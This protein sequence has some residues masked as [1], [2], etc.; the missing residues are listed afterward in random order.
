MRHVRIVVGLLTW[1]AAVMAVVWSLKT[2]VFFPRED[3]GRLVNDLWLFAAA[4]RREV[5][6]QLD[7][8]WPV[9][10][11]DPIYVVEGLG[12]YRQ[13]GEIRRVGMPG[14][15]GDSDHVDATLLQALLY[16]SAPQLTDGT[17]LTYYTTPESLT[18]VMETMLPPE[19]RD[20][21]AWEITATY[22][23]YHAE[24][25][26]ALKPVIMAGVF[27]ALRVVEDDLAEAVNRRRAELEQLASRYQEQVV[28][29]EVVPLV[30]NEIWPIVRK[31]AEPVAIE[32]GEKIWDRA[33]LWRFGWRYFYDVSPLPQK[34]LARGEWNRFLNEEVRPVMTEYT[35]LLVTLQKDVLTEIAQNPNVREAV[36]RNLRQIIDDPEFRAIVW[37]IVREVV[38][39]NPR[40]RA[41]LEERWQGEDARRAFQYAADIA[42][43][44]VR[45]IGDLL[46]G[47]KEEG[48]SPEFAQVLRNLHKDKCWFVIETTSVA[49]AEEGS[50]RHLE[51]ATVLP[52]HR[53]AY[54]EV[55]PFTVQSRGGDR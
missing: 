14:R 35:P 20:M 17:A 32:V 23:E 10:V 15:S 42:E 29:K 37:Q 22:Q 53:G 31:H 11:G 47:T 25:L 52:V 16:P 49:G 19:K 40:L 54:P 44:S 50:A 38:I 26:R 39:D 45:R 1:V 4:D 28:E 7:T 46:M 21:I 5:T 3:G 51:E 24:I 43:P 6:L 12:T 9:E 30:R 27:D 48:I 55:N 41:T 13:V 36:N 33:S 18:W 34:D 2:S 8:A